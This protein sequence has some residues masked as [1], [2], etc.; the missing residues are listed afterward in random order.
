MLILTD[1]S[2]P[3]PGAMAHLMMLQAVSRQALGGCEEVEGLL[4]FACGL[5]HHV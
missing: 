2:F 4:I 5:L 3:S 1:P